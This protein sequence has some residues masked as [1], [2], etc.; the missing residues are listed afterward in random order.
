MSKRNINY[1]FLILIIVL[2]FLMLLL[3][4]RYYPNC[5]KNVI[6]FFEGIIHNKELA[7]VLAMLVFYALPVYIL[8]KIY[9]KIN[10]RRK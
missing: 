5:S 10:K 7:A 4:N 1:F 8:I 9:E 6:I 2:P 3:I